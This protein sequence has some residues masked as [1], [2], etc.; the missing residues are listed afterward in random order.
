MRASKIMTSEIVTCGPDESVE[1][2]LDKLYDNSVRMLP[3]VDENRKILGVI[4]G[5]SMLSRVA[6]EYI[7]SGDLEPVHFA[8]DLGLLRRRFHD[9]LPLKVSDV[10]DK[11]PGVIKLDES[12]LAATTELI[13]HNR[14]GYLLVAD[15]EHKLQGIISCNDVL[16]ALTRFEAGEQS[17]A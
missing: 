2:A 10:M 11:K 17:D 6:P 9:V 7:S 14:Y 1:S 15:D 8:P 16:K 3:V 4:G 13:A 5:L 12:L